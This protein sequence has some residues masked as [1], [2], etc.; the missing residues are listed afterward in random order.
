MLRNKDAH[1]KQTSFHTCK[2]KQTFFSSE[3]DL[4]FQAFEVYKVK[5]KCKLH[6]NSDHLK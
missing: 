2:I 4:S 1:A 5:N 6:H 3:E